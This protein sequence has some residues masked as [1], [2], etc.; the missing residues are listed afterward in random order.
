MINKIFKILRSL[1]WRLVFIFILMTLA[2]M[3][4]ASIS[5]NYY[6]ESY[7]Y[8]TFKTKIE[9]GF[10]EWN[11]RE[12]PTREEITKYL[13]DERNAIYLFLMSGYKTYTIIEKDTDEIVYSSDKLFE[14][15]K[16]KLMDEIQ[17]SENYVAALAGKIGDNDKLINYGDRVYFDYA[18]QT[19]KF[20]LYFRYDR[21]EWKSTINKFNQIIQVSFIIAV[22]ASLIVGFMLSKTIT[23]PI[24]NL[25]HYARRIASG[26]FS[27]M[28]EVKSDDEIG[29][30]TKTFN[31]MARELE[32][33]LEEQKKLDNMRKEFVANVSHELRTPLTSI[34]SYAEA[35]ID[36]DVEEKETAYKFLK[37]ID[38]ETER[39][40]RL[41]RDLL[42][43]S[44]LDNEQMQ[45]NMREISIGDVLIDSV[46][47]VALSAKSKRQEIFLSIEDNLSHIIADKDRMEQVF[48]NV[49][50][51][52]IKYTP[53]EGEI[54]V[55]LAV[56]NDEMYLQVKD[57]GIGI[58]KE[59]MP[60]IFERFYRVDKARSRE[61]GGTGLGL[62]IAKEIVDAHKGTISI[63]SV[64]GA[65]T[66]ISIAL[67]IC[68]EY[69]NTM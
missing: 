53:E 44:K 11:L 59:D 19:G 20:I 66:N 64:V 6:V 35:L 25:M 18:R 55:S 58:P 8:D 34:K 4:F 22:F 13:R 16:D 54:K 5:L 39:M 63:E 32:R 65:G 21:E 51:N 61:M 26:N 28:A 57:T 36:G 46:D 67:P 69:L 10:Q 1:Q 40:T 47:K 12:N 49:L 45:W 56:A 60:R 3:I 30:L 43:L 68:N 48:L 41:V 27:E 2:L 15:E 29:E 7:Y 14:Q 37:V 31:Y 42:Q 52:A 50:T 62:A 33:T 17:K 9:K 23:V 38:S 24:I